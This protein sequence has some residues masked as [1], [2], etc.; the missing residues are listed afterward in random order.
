MVERA[1]RTGGRVD[2]ARGAVRSFVRFFLSGAAVVQKLAEV[3][4]ARSEG[5]PAAV[6]AAPAAYAPRARTHDLCVSGAAAADRVRVLHFVRQTD[7]DGGPNR[8]AGPTSQR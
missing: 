8:P 1:E 6:A 4:A 2:A 7:G 3:F 5:G